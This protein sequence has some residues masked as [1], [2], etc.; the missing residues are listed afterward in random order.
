ML[1]DFLNLIYKEFIKSRVKN[2]KNT[3]SYSLKQK[4]SIELIAKL[5]DI[6]CN[7]FKFILCMFIFIVLFKLNVYLGILILGGFILYKKIVNEEFEEEFKNKSLNFKYILNEILKDN[8]KLKMK[9]ILVIVILLNF[10][11]YTKFYL[12]ILITLLIFTIKDIYSNIKNIPTK[13][14]NEKFS[15]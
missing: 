9:S 6:L 7:I 2:L 1:N 15:K 8:T 4:C 3:N 12:T 5:D 14:F 10:S 11:T 13:F